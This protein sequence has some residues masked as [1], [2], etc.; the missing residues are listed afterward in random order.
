MQTITEQLSKVNAYFSSVKPALDLGDSKVVTV[1]LTA[2]S[3]VAS[4]FSYFTLP[5]VISYTLVGISVLAVAATAA[6][7]AKISRKTAEATEKVAAAPVVTP[8]VTKPV[9]QPTSW[10][11][12]SSKAPEAV[13]PAV[14]EATQAEA[15]VA[16]APVKGAV[17]AVKAAE[18]VKA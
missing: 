16:A 5:H 3:L 8:E 4:A 13:K 10:I 15:K 7:F 1:A 18:V 6:L 12:W 9:A 2:L 14:V 17:V 11:F